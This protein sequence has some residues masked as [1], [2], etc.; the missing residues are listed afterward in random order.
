MSIPRA[1]CPFCIPANDCTSIRSVIRACQCMTLGY[2][3]AFS[4]RCSRCLACPTYSQRYHERALAS[5]V[6]FSF[7]SLPLAASYVFHC[8]HHSPPRTTPSSLVRTAMPDSTK[9]A[10]HSTK[11]PQQILS[12]YIDYA[13]LSELVQVLNKD[14]NEPHRV[15]VT[16]FSLRTKSSRLTQ[17]SES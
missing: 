5:A 17:C 14:S 6:R 16:T 15:E 2:G 10:E 8:C 11:Q 12:H 9:S 13:R 7:L 4:P 1:H 3:G